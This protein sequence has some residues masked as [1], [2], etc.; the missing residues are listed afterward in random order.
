LLISGAIPKRENETKTFTPFAHCQR[1]KGIR[2]IFCDETC[3]NRSSGLRQL[4]LQFAVEK[5]NKVA[6]GRARKM[7]NGDNDQAVRVPV[8]ANTL[9]LA[10][11]LSKEN[12]EAKRPGGSSKTLAESI[13]VAMAAWRCFFQTGPPQN[14]SS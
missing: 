9:R 11:N 14:S 12:P 2:M 13:I 3:K 5:F 10:P 7:V 6:M 4:P 8:L 1:R